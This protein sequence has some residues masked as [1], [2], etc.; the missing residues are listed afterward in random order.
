MGLLADVGAQV[1]LGKAVGA[2]HPRQPAQ[3]DLVH[4]KGHHP[5]PRRALE[6]V[7]HQPRRQQSFDRR[8]RHRPV[9][10]QQVVP[11]LAHHPRRAG[12]RIRAVPRGQQDRVMLLVRIAI[13]K[14]GRLYAAGR[15]MSIV[16]HP[17]RLRIL[18]AMELHEIRRGSS[19]RKASQR[20]SPA[21]RI[22]AVRGSCFPHQVSS[23]RFYRK[24]VSALRTEGSCSPPH[25]V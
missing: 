9:R 1:E 17:L 21:A 3:L 2:R 20:S 12:Q 6:G 15:H 19:L 23:T 25:S 4:H 24:A 8:R 11:P 7:R 22:R 14:P 13:L 18:T 16:R 5:Q 10:E